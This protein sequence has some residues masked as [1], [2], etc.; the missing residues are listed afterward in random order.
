MVEIMLELI[1]LLL[2]S[3]LKSRVH[4]IHDGILWGIS[5]DAGTSIQVGPIGNTTTSGILLYLQQIFRKWKGYLL[6]LLIPNLNQLRPY[7]VIDTFYVANQTKEIDLTSIFDFE[8]EI[9][10]PDLLNTEAVFLLQDPSQDLI[11][12]SISYIYRTAIMS[13]KDTSIWIRCKRITC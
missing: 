4:T 11:L 8:K 5:V 12:M 6:L 1:Q 9:I 7:T 2:R 10:T 13:L 3:K